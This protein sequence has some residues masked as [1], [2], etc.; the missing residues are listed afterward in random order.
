MA[1]S[2]GDRAKASKIRLKVDAGKA[3]ADERA[4]LERYDASVT[5]STIRKAKALPSAS[6]HTP[7]MRPREERLKE[8]VRELGEG[9]HDAALD[10][11]NAGALPPREQLTLPE[12][13]VIHETERLDDTIAP[14]AF[15][16]SPNVPPPPEDAAPPPPGAP[17]PPTPGAPLV[18]EQAPA[19]GQGDPAAA[20]QYAMFAAWIVGSGIAAGLELIPDDAPIPPVVLQMLEDEDSHKK[21]I[22]AVGEATHRLCIKYNVRSAPLS[23]E[24]AVG[25]ALTASILAIVAVQRRKLKERQQV[26]PAA[27]AP[28]SSGS[29]RVGDIDPTAPVPVPP[30][31]EGV[32]SL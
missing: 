29:A 18:D 5:G 31:L 12:G 10:A 7:T 15:T 2:S 32:F 28:A 19:Q 26:K 21:A 11:E 1:A 27:A 6:K 16:F 9:K 13:V 25:G 20:A 14:E 24:L 22:H 30:G 23:D 17:P 4:W 8:F 3:T